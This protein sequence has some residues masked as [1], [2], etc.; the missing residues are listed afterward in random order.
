MARPKS[1]A[2]VPV[3]ASAVVAVA[4]HVAETRETRFI[5]LANGRTAEAVRQIGLLGNLAAPAYNYTEEQL[6]KIEAAI[7]DALRLS[8]TQ[9]RARQAR[10]SPQRSFL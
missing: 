1:T 7:R 6:G 5:R 8:M 9:L 3:P 4:E 2:L 10:R